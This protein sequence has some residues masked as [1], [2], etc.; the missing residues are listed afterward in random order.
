M[1]AF[2]SKLLCKLSK[3]ICTFFSIEGERVRTVCLLC[4]GGSHI[5]SIRQAICCAD[6]LEKNSEKKCS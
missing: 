1:K 6:I 5:M 4:P 2:L 3:K